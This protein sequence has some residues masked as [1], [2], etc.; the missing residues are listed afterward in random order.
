MRDKRQV[1]DYKYINLHEA[2]PQSRGASSRGSSGCGRVD[3]VHN[4][5]F[6]LV[7]DWHFAPECCEEKNILL[8][9]I[10]VSAQKETL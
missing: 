7:H 3:I 1:Y 10:K 8:K 9:N 5:V 6:S 4:I 2:Y